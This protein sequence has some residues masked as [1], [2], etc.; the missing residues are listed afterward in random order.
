VSIATVVQKSSEKDMAQLI[1]ITHCVKEQ[2]LRDA[3]AVIDG[4]S[5]LKEINNVIRLEG[6]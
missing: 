4:M 2:N 1:M 3:L 5:I 6:I